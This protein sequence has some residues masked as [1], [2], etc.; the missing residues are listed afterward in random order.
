MIDT[1]RPALPPP[2]QTRVKTDEILIGFALDPAEPSSET[3]AWLESLA[4]T[5]TRLAPLP[6]GSYSCRTQARGPMPAGLR[7]VLA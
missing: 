1:A 3:L 5:L 6:V 4:E 2:L 7:R